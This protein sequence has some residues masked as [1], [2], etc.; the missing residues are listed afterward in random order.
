[1]SL[2]TPFMGLNELKSC[3]K[4]KSLMIRLE[5]FLDEKYYCTVAT[6]SIWAHATICA[7]LDIWMIVALFWHR[8]RWSTQW[9]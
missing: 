2:L 9:L 4:V 5:N 1:M 3:Q 6:G 7:L 8:F